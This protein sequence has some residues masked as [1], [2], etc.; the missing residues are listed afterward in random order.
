MHP[1]QR[2]EVRTQI[3]KL[4]YYAQQFNIPRSE[5]VDAIQGKLGI[6]V[7]PG[8]TDSE[9]SAFKGELRKLIDEMLAER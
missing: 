2:Q 9:H 1:K 7:T 6:Q 4:I 5:M 3:R 8:I